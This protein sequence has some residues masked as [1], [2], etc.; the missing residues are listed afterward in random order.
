MWRRT[1]D[2]V[3]VPWRRGRTGKA[4]VFSDGAV[5]ACQD[6][7]RGEPHHEEIRR[8]CGKAEAVVATLGIARDGLAVPYDASC[9]SSWLEERLRA[10]DSSLRLGRADVWHFD[11]PG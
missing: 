9:E 4:L 6:D 11:E 2:I 10:H 7:A 3:L 1:E 8:A 5:V